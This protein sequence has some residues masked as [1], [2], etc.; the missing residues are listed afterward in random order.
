MQS[1]FGDTLQGEGEEIEQRVP[2][3][4]CLGRLSTENILLRKNMI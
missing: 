3:K 1:T 2:F 4:S